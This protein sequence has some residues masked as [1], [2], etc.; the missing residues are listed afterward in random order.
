MQ[1]GDQLVGTTRL[2]VRC[3]FLANR[4]F[5]LAVVA[6]IVLSWALSNH[7][8]SLLQISSND[9]DSPSTMAG[10]RLLMLIGIVMALATDRLLTALSQII[11][12]ARLGD[13]FVAANAT[14]LRAIGWSLLILQLLD[15]PAA[16][17]TRFFPSLG[18]AAPNGDISVGG[19]IAVLMVFVLSRVFAA[20]SVMRDEL[21]ATV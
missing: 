17:L 6:G 15:I 12:S 19:W 8:A 11:A 20:G 1:R 5:L 9:V 2:I 3:A 14:R 18:S 10:M 21:E 16:L 7:F 4:A 13:P